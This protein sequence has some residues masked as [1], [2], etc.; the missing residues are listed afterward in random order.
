MARR[1]VAFVSHRRELVPGAIEL[2][3]VAAVDAVADGLAEL[4]RNRAAQF[5]RQ[6]RNAP[7]RIE[8]VRSDDRLCR[9]HVDARAAGSAMAACRGVRRQRQ[10]RIQFAEKKPRSGI[11]VDQVRVFADPA[12]PG[13]LGNRFLEYGR[14]IDKSTVSEAPHGSFDSRGQALKPP[15]QDLV[16]VASQCIA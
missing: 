6:V 8:L 2:A 15:A 3:V 9:T 4:D 7:A 11:F 1:K 12:E 5:D 14:A 10:V 16:V 13:F